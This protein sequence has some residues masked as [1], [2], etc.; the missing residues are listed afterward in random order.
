MR[1]RRLFTA[2][3]LAALVAV[4]IAG[5]GQKGPLVPPKASAVATIAT[6]HAGSGDAHAMTVRA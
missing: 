1:F 4:G 2:S 6:P 3:L 5:C